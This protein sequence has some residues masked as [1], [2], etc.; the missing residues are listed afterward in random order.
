[1]RLQRCPLLVSQRQLQLEHEP[2]QRQGPCAVSVQSSRTV[3]LFFS[4]LQGGG[5]HLFSARLCPDERC[6]A[7]S[8]GEGKLAAWD[9]DAEGG[10]ESDKDDDD[11]RDADGESGDVGSGADSASRGAVGLGGVRL[12]DRTVGIHAVHCGDS[13]RDAWIAAI[14]RCQVPQRLRILATLLQRGQLTLVSVPASACSP[15][16]DEGSSCVLLARIFAGCPCQPDESVAE[17]KGGEE[18]VSEAL[19]AAE[20]DTGSLD[21]CR[22]SLSNDSSP[23]VTMAAAQEVVGCDGEKF[24][25]LK[26]GF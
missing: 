4:N 19:P 10:D 9:D 7:T 12:R 17:G 6:A 8:V 13:T 22:G 1:M 11:N 18:E 21:S 3:E 16:G 23:V 15:E 24:G 5:A 14:L 2:A 26:Q 25:Y 20:P